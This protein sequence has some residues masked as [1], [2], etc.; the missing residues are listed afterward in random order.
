MSSFNLEFSLEYCMSLY[1]NMMIMFRADRFP[2]T[3]T[4]IHQFP[5]SHWLIKCNGIVQF[6]QIYNLLIE[7]IQHIALLHYKKMLK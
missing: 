2:L 6:Y 7:P 4:V 3:I 1:D 5:I